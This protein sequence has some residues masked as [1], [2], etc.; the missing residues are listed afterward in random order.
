MKVLVNEILSHRLDVA[1][2]NKYFTNKVQKCQIKV[3]LFL[4][5]I[6]W[7]H[8]FSLETF[9]VDLF[10]NITLQK[11]GFWVVLLHSNLILKTV[12]VVNLSVPEVHISLQRPWS[13]S[14]WCWCWCGTVELWKGRDERGSERTRE[15]AS[16]GTGGR[17]GHQHRPGQ[18]AARM[19][20][21]PDRFKAAAGKT[22]GKIHRYA[23]IF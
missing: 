13:T 17:A 9:I 8:F 3:L 19:E 4:L 16:G 6:N 14:E 1:I 5:Q 2:W 15:R 12:W 23:Q 10:I 22:L 18:E 11:N 21:R 20:I 7:R